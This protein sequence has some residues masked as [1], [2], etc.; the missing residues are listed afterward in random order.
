MKKITFLLLTIFCSIVGY[1]QFPENF[2]DPSVTVPNGFP[3]GWLVTDNG[4]GTGVSWNIV[5]NAALVING[6][7]SAYINRQ[8]IGQ[9]NTSEDWLISPAKLIPTNGQLR[10]KAK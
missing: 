1:S 10:F 5:S 4:V 6:T 3:T 8:E 7:K 2:E 9:G